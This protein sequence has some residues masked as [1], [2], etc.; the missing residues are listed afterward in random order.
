MVIL[1]T[2][3]RVSANHHTKGGL[4]NP[5]YT[6]KNIPINSLKASFF[7]K[8]GALQVYPRGKIPQ[9]QGLKGDVQ[10]IYDIAKKLGDVETKPPDKSFLIPSQ[11]SGM[12]SRYVLGAGARLYHMSKAKAK[13][14]NLG[15]ASRDFAILKA[16]TKLKV[17]RQV[18]KNKGLISTA[19]K[20]ERVKNGEP[21][22][23]LPFEKMF[24][25]SVAKLE[26]D[27]SSL[28]PEER[29]GFE[30][31]IATVK[32]T[33]DEKDYEEAYE[34]S[35]T[36]PACPYDVGHGAPTIHS[37]I[38]GE[39][40]VSISIGNQTIVVPNSGFNSAF[41][42]ISQA[43]KENPGRGEKVVE[44][45]RGRLREKVQS[46]R[47]E[48]GGEREKNGDVV[49]LASGGKGKVDRKKKEGDRLAR[50]LQEKNIQ[51]I[52]EREK[53]IQEMRKPQNG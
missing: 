42:L 5:A 12:C 46:I 13:G 51:K 50:K 21:P 35:K 41:N 14:V 11:K 53:R 30:E 8:M 33:S 32:E 9:K 24:M 10:E 26:R 44:D 48:R 3:N 31:F 47:E 23:A 36:A 43:L 37:D 34:L 2:G 25:F 49:S 40:S 20:A 15:K 18:H 4:I 22:P 45:F 27:I 7:E 38:V 1:N 39:S 17:L 19:C 52:E 29:R 6:I 16:K 28:P